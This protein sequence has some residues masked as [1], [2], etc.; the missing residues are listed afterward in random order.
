VV[1]SLMLLCPLLFL[2]RRQVQRGRW[3]LI[4]H[5]IFIIK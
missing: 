4:M 3:F 1:S 2:W 5:Q